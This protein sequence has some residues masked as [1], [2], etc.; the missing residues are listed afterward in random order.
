MPLQ[1]VFLSSAVRLQRFELSDAL[2]CNTAK[3]ISISLKKEKM[4]WFCL[5]FKFYFTSCK[6]SL[7]PLNAYLFWYLSPQDRSPKTQS[8]VRRMIE[9]GQMDQRARQPPTPPS[10]P[11]SPQTNAPAHN[12]AVEKS[13][14]VLT[15][16]EQM[17]RLALRTAV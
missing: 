1:K 9:A 3:D 6:V 17:N 7:K 15:H 11:Q 2:N 4:T 10:S 8:Q 13:E 14:S 5:P 12:P 16:G